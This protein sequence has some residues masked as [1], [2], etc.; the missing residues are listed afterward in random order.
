MLP[1]IHLLLYIFYLFVFLWLIS[2]WHFFDIKKLSRL[3][4]GI[5]FLMKVAAGLLLTVIYTFYYTNLS[6]NDIYRY[7]NDSAIL[8]KVLF[9]NPVA[10]LK[11]M[12]GIGLNQPD[13][14]KHLVD[15]QNFSHSCSDWVTNNSFIIRLNVLLNYLSLTNIWIN[16]LFFNF[17]SF[18]GLVA[19]YKA[20]QSYF[21]PVESKLYLPIFL[22][23]SVVFWSSG[24]LKESIFF[25]AFG[26]W[27]HSFLRLVNSRKKVSDMFI[28][29]FTSW[30]ILSVKL[31]VFIL[32]L[33]CGFIYITMTA[34]RAARWINMA[35][36]S[37]FVFT[38]LV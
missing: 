23:P 30:L 20:I 32:V 35:I 14:F 21:K 22:M 19:L 37:V 1:F 7:F 33:F 38:G 31:H 29:A 16:T 34:K 13:V 10:W 24:I 27:L 18:I 3:Q 6:H 11:I 36:C 28:I 17:F 25:M 12:L 4:L 5:F 9:Q 2:K 8:S 15:T 26:F